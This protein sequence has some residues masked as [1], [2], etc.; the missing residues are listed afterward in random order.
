LKTPSA[1][2]ILVFE[3]AGTPP[4]DERSQRLRLGPR[5]DDW[6]VNVLRLGAICYF[7]RNATVVSVSDGSGVG[8]P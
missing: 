4:D 1:A 8:S 2:P 5:A 7:K 3:G 6:S